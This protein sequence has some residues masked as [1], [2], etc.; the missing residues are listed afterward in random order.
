M[1]EENKDIFNLKDLEVFAKKFALKL[2][3][4]S[5]ILLKGDLG[6]GKTTFIRFI[7]NSL[8]EINKLNKPLQIN[9]PSF[10]ILLTYDL[11]NYEI[12]HYDFYRI[13]NVSELKELDIFENFSDSISFIEWPEIILE[14]FSNINYYLIEMK[15]V[16]DKTRKMNLN[17]IKN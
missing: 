11:K 14:N 6:S 12:Y 4:G 13:Q 15:T 3:K 17:F 2:N 5:L 10:P 9:S 1:I 16:T 8:F 7:I